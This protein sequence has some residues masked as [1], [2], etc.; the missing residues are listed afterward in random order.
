MYSC[1]RKFLRMKIFVAK[2]SADKVKNGLHLYD[3]VQCKR[4][5]SVLWVYVKV[6]REVHD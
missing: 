1:A 2:L 5:D 4:Q 3:L 6:Y